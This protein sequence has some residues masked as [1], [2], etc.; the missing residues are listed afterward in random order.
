MSF[1]L[2]YGK[3]IAF[4]FRFDLP[5]QMSFGTRMAIKDFTIPSLLAEPSPRLTR[6][7]SCE[8]AAFDL[9]ANASMEANSMY[10]GFRE[11]GYFAGNHAR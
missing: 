11:R 9:V 7:K 4:L 6:S 1:T 10:K 5:E 8:E 2:S 3:F